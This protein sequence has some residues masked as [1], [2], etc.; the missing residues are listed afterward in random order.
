MKNA[1]NPRKPKL[2]TT[3]HNGTVFHPCYT[4]NDWGTEGWFIGA[5]Y[6][7]SRGETHSIAMQTDKRIVWPFKADVLW[8]DGV[9][10]ETRITLM[11]T[12][13]S[14]VSDHGN[15]YSVASPVYGAHFTS[16]GAVVQIDATELLFDLSTIVEDRS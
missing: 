10:R 16:R 9:V 2:T 4:V 12:D 8:Q 11:R 13:H 15:S 3:T 7:H 5:D 1:M 6:Q 14:S